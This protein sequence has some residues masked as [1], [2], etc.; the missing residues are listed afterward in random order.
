LPQAYTIVLNGG[1]ALV[2]V[3]ADEAQMAQ[4]LA[5]MERYMT[6]EFE[7]QALR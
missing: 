2:S 3:V 1:G 5:L 6:E 4:A 7:A